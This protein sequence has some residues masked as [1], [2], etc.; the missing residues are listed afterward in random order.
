M[1]GRPL[2]PLQRASMLVVA[3][4]WLVCGSG[5]AYVGTLGFTTLPRA[6]S[7]SSLC[8]MLGVGGVLGAF[9]FVISALA[10]HR[11]Y[12]FEAEIPDANPDLSSDVDDD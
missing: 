1:H 6:R 3:V 4:L 11:P 2:T 9:R 5:L 7:L 12:D 10:P 8:L